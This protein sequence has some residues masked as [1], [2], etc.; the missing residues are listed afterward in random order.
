MVWVGAR[1]G[2]G[3]RGVGTQGPCMPEANSGKTRLPWRYA[4]SSVYPNPHEGQTAQRL[5][6]TISMLIA[7][8]CPPAFQPG[9]RASEHI[10][11]TKISTRFAAIT[12]PTRQFALSS[13]PAFPVAT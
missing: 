4:V 5:D 12:P 10:M 8:P 1:G 3:S 2:A 7:G 13:G 9:R 6:A 11:A